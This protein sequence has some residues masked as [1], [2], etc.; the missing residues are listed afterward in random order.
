MGDLKLFELDNG[1]AIELPGT[2]MTLEKSLQTL[3]EKNMETLFGVRCLASEYSTGKKHAGRMDSLGIDENGNPVIFEYKRAM[4]DNVITQGLF[5]LDWLMDHRGDFELQVLK[6]LGP[7]VTVDWSNPRLV[8]VA[9]D[10]NRYDEH[11]I[12]QMN[13]SIELVRYR[14]YEDRLLALD[15][16]ASTS[17]KATAAGEQ[18]GP[19]TTTGST[20]TMNNTK[21][22]SQLHEA[23]SAQLKDV[24]DALEQYL[25]NLGDDVSKIV[26]K[27]YY[28]FRR[29][30]NFACVEVHPQSAELLVY[31][32]VNPDEVTLEADFSRDVR[33]IGHFGTGDLELTLASSEDVVRAQPLLDKSYAAS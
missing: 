1:M 16:V 15:L 4:N 10:F 23:A 9:G 25:L 11:A 33:S 19:I 5:Y 6:R 14:S 26:N 2:A 20:K 12:G 7:T 8:C 29:L 31:V 21:T 18:S 24:Y 13:R 22:V 3:I 30:K 17:A 27:N 32:K 28:A